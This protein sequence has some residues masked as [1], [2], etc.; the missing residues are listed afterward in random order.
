MT[1][2]EIEQ[3]MLNIHD[4]IHKPGFAVNNFE[5]IDADIAKHIR[6]N[7]DCFPVEKAQFLFYPELNNL[8]MKAHELNNLLKNLN[9]KSSD[10]LNLLCE[11]KEKEANSIK[12][13][14]KAISLVN[15]DLHD[16][17]KATFGLLIDENIPKWS[18][19]ERVVWIQKMLEEM[20]EYSRDEVINFLEGLIKRLET[21]LLETQDYRNRL[22][23]EANPFL[24]IP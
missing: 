5:P 17:I 6:D 2:T 15:K 1:V 8:F 9:Q 23:K 4:N 20:Q 7:P 21:F 13:I 10:A 22:F 11:F 16:Y 24:A 14:L 12:D 3:L 18:K 19:E